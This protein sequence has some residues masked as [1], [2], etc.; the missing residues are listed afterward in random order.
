MRRSYVSKWISNYA[1]PGDVISFSDFSWTFPT[2]IG[3]WGIREYQ[4]H[5]FGIDSIWD[6][7]HTMMYLGDKI[8][9]VEPPRATYLTPDTWNW[10]KVSIHRYTK[11]ILKDSDI[12]IF[13]SIFNKING[14][15]Y[16]YG[17]LFDIMIAQMFGYPYKY[18]RIFDFH[19]KWFVC[20]VGIGA[21]FHKWRKE[22]ERLGL[23][24]PPRLFSELNPKAWSSKFVRKFK[25]NG[26]R[27]NIESI[28]PG[29]FPNAESHLAGEFKEIKSI[30]LS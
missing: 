17:Q 5:L 30:C 14:T 29:L 11:V 28:C 18:K 12:E 15:P 7:V 23:Y 4:K 8:F 10:K 24:V 19:K 16:D 26:S 20:S 2:F 27:W 13:R 25:E 3:C 21:G 6:V 9:S 22:R 1:I